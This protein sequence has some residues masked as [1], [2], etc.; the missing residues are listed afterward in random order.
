MKTGVKKPRFPLRES[1]GAMVRMTHLA[2]AQDLQNHLAGHDIPVGMWFYL[3]ALWEEDGLTQRVLSDRV[4]AT[5]ATTAQQLAKMEA[6]GYIERRRSQVDRRNSHV[7][8]TRSGRALQDKLLPYA[9]T[10]NANALA[11]FTPT[12]VTQLLDLLARLR[13]NLEQREQARA[14]RSEAAQ[15]AGRRKRRSATSHQQ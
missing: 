12:D 13:S 14:T 3:R 6:R 2:F 11:G 7:H 8:L 15:T 9:V 4:G 5:E 1:V 10:V